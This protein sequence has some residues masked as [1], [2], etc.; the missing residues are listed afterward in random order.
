MSRT[1]ESRRQTQLLV[2][3]TGEFQ[4][5]ALYRLCRIL[6]SCEKLTSVSILG[7]SADYDLNPLWKI[8]PGLRTVDLSQGQFNLD[9]LLQLDKLRELC[10][11]GHALAELHDIAVSNSG[12]VATA[13]FLSAPN[14]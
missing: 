3:R 2:E 12:K 13:P 4:E 11:D 1:Q 7:E 5:A 6:A 9:L 10:I 8:L 14:V